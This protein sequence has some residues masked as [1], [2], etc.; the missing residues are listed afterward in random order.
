MFS[1]PP[2]IFT[3]PPNFR[4]TMKLIIA[5]VLI[6][7]V[8]VKGQSIPILPSCAASC[9]TDICGGVAD[10]NFQCFCDENQ[11]FEFEG[12]WSTNCSSTDIGSAYVALNRACGTRF[13]T[14]GPD[15]RRAKGD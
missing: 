10:S 14:T 7:S 3:S 2:F 5:T 8:F 15:I 11:Q 1:T 13:Y 12:C 4:Q 6:S 9:V